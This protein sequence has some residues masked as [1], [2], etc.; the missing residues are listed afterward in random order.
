[1]Q[2][3]PKLI[4]LHV[5]TV[6]MQ[7]ENFVGIQAKQTQ[8]IT[9]QSIRQWVDA[10]KATVLDV[11]CA[12]CRTGERVT[13]ECIREM[14]YP[15]DYAPPGSLPDDEGPYEKKL[16][17]VHKVVPI[18]P[19][20]NNIFETRNLGVTLEM[21]PTYGETGLVDLRIAPELVDQVGFSEWVKFKDEWGQADR[22][23][24]TFLTHRVNTGSTL[25]N[26]RFSLV[27][28]FT[29]K[30]GNGDLDPSRKILLFVMPE[31]IKLPDPM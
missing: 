27:T 19:M 3:R 4:R 30:K 23:F 11:H 21:E 22:K 6:G 31:V 16:E 10:G 28:T 18:R 24:P 5:M 17:E 29:G 2:D 13:L 15:S 26:G 14:I 25:V 8:G 9:Y 12:T 1:M 20:V 7:Q